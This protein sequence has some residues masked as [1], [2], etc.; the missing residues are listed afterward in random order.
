MIVGA[1]LLVLVVS[2]GGAG[3][4][5]EGFETPPTVSTIVP[6]RLRVVAGPPGRPLADAG[7]NGLSFPDYVMTALGEGDVVAGAFVD[8]RPGAFFVGSAADGTWESIDPPPVEGETVPTMVTVGWDAVLVG[9][10]CPSAFNPDADTDPSCPGGYDGVGLW[11]LDHETLRWTPVALL[12]PDALGIDDDHLYTSVIGTGHD[13]VYVVVDGGSAPRV[14]RVAMDGTTDTVARWTEDPGGQGSVFVRCVTGSGGLVGEVRTEGASS[15]G[16]PEIG[17]SMRRTG[18]SIVAVYPPGADTWTFHD[19]VEMTHLQSIGCAADSFAIVGET[20]TSLAVAEWRRVTLDGRQIGRTVLADELSLAPTG[21]ATVAFSI[22]DHQQFVGSG[23]PGLGF[24]R[25]L[26][27][28]VITDDEG[29]LG[30]PVRPDH[31]GRG[32]Q[33]AVLAG[34][35]GPPLFHHYPADRIVVAERA[36]RLPDGRIAVLVRFTSDRAAE[37]DELE[38]LVAE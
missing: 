19:T 12:G 27:D 38:L 37:D 35:D 34:P 9:R 5:D 32:R 11:R 36:S 31:L 8:F 23:G 10:V 3:S 30:D 28:L 29:G 24:V 16:G 26:G 33:I 4:S 21:N 17:E 25:D 15:V 7:E 22:T 1:A 18:T 6:D 13:A 14:V 2:C 20:D